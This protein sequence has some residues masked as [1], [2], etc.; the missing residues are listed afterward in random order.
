MVILDDDEAQVIASLIDADWQSF[1]NA[2]TEHGY[3]A[4]EA[5]EI[6][7]KLHT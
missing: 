2:C 3:T 7:H 1:Q 6:W 5:H 4:E